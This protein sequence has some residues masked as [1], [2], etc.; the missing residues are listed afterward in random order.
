[1]P[2]PASRSP[3]P[4]SAPRTARRSPSATEGFALVAAAE[5]FTLAGL[6]LFDIRAVLRDLARGPDAPAARVAKAEAA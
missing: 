3:T 2:P 5:R 1:M 6:L 4:T